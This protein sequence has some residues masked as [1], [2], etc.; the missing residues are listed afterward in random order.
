[1]AEMTLFDRMDDAL[2]QGYSHEDVLKIFAN[3]IEAYARA[4]YM[5][6]CYLSNLSDEEYDTV[7][8]GNTNVTR[9]L[10]KK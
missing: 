7:V 1:M 10:A 3:E 2:E 6:E 4:E 8:N 5:R 9:W